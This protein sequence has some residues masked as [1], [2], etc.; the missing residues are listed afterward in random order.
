MSHVAP[1]TAIG[2]V[3]LAG[4]V[5][6]TEVGAATRAAT[7]WHRVGHVVTFVFAVGACGDNTVPIGPPLEHTATLFLGAHDDDDFIFMEPDLVASLAGSSSTTIYATTAGPHGPNLNLMDAAKVAYG[8]TVGSFEWEC[9]SISIGTIVAEHCRLRD[10][11]VSIVD[12][13]LPDGGIPGD[14]KE[15]LLH[16]IDGSIGELDGYFGGSVD[17]D[18]VIEVF[19]EIYNATTPDAVQ[20]L[21]LAGS[22]GRDHSSHMFVGSIG[23]WAAARV[24]YAGPITWNRG[25]NVD[26]EVPTLDGAA[27]RDARKL[28]GYYEACADQCGPCGESCETL[29]ASH[30]IWIARQYQTTRVLE[31]SGTLARGDS[32]LDATLALGDC[33][34]AAH[35]D[36]S[37]TGTLRVADQ[38]VTSAATDDLALAPCT[39]APEQFW[40][41]DSEG[42]VWNGR[43]PQHAVNMT[44]DHT[45][46][47][48]GSSA[49]ICGATFE[50][51]WVFGP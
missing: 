49:P 4:T 40:V 11:P 9:G 45:R 18:S 32:C 51:H 39:G 5:I 7:K 47:L 8:S 28:L 43:L 16:L 38:C 22:H 48:A 29:N 19:A 25:Y 24:A 34:N 12:L 36:L 37:P 31:A 26:A 30:E 33:T 42:A 27:L 17:A 20:T 44:Y 46:C 35:F 1:W 50:P 14:R 41:L 23:L 13:G 3:P 21:E 6:A 10:R 15:S 2:R